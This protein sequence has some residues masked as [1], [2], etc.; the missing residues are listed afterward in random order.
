M[1]RVALNTAIVYFKKHKR[2]EDAY[3]IIAQEIEMP[4][5]DAETKELQL[6]HFY[7]A[8]QQL[9][10]IEKA[11]MF[12]YLEDYLN[13]FFPNVLGFLEPLDH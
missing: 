13:P 4:S 8:L 2:K 3:A 9:D 10:K 12:Y 7:K 5:E 11:L 1:Y 6:A